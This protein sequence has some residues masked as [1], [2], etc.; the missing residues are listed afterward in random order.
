MV[1]VSVPEEVVE[2]FWS[3]ESHSSKRQT[4]PSAFH[5]TET[6]SP[7]LP[8]ESRPSQGAAALTCEAR[9]SHSLAIPGQEPGLES[10][11]LRQ[12]EKIQNR[13]RTDSHKKP[14][15]LPSWMRLR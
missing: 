1:C 6:R 7:A 12:K 14:Q 10:L 15:E 5:R 11:R 8:S 9:A 3:P 4:H 13:Y 2:P